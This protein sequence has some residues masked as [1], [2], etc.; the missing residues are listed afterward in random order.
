MTG[1]RLGMEH[2]EI[3]YQA[4]PDCD[5]TVRL[6]RGADCKQ[7]EIHHLI[8]RFDPNKQCQSGTLARPLTATQDSIRRTTIN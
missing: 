2:D 5:E 3:F 7:V 1:E 6:V 4:C 8:T